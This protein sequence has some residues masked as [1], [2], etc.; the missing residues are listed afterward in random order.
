M[1][2]LAEIQRQADELSREDKAGLLAYLLH[3]LEGA[4]Q[5]PDDDEVLRR[6]VDLESGSV[7]A[8]SH[9]EFVLRMR[10]NRT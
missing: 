7:E 9:E 8:I 5:G 3:T 2:R 4:P 1:V 6:D 10:P